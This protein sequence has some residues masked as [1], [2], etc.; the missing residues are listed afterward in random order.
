MPGSKWSKAKKNIIFDN[1][2]KG[3][4]G[5]LV[6]NFGAKIAMLKKWSTSAINLYWH[7]PYTVPT[8]A[9][10]PQAP[11]KNI[12]LF[13]LAFGLPDPGWFS[14]KR[15]TVGLLK[16]NTLLALKRIG[17]CGACML[18]KPM[19]HSVYTKKHWGKWS[20]TGMPGTRKQ[21]ESMILQL[22]AK[23]LPPPL[24]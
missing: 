14:E 5:F 15:K 9:P 10:A 12:G 2:V 1:A 4:S 20:K 24:G 22:C 21:I 23:P 8:T 7:G 3:K 6:P 17:A 11:K 16:K 13:F 18:S 19:I